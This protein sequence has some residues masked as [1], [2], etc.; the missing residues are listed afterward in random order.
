[1]NAN[2]RSKYLLSKPPWNT[3]G[4]TGNPKGKSVVL[5]LSA[6]VAVPTFR[7]CVRK[8]FTSLVLHNLRKDPVL[9]NTVSELSIWTIEMKFMEVYLGSNR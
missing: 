6:S 1:M 4:A 5:C 7:F 2:W 3:I 9:A 8:P